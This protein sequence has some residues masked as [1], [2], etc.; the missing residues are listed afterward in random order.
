MMFLRQLTALGRRI[1][2]LQFT[3]EV[4][5]EGFDPKTITILTKC[6]EEGGELRQ[7]VNQDNRFHPILNLK[8]RIWVKD[9]Y[10]YTKKKEYEPK[11]ADVSCSNYQAD[12]WKIYNA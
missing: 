3:Q 6:D 8:S 12:C 9:R 4:M 11:H 2:H 10:L 1:V 7:N 5:E